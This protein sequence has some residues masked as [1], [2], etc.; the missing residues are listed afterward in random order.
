[1]AGRQAP[2]MHVIL[3]YVV[4]IMIYYSAI[5]K[6]MLLQITNPISQHDVICTAMI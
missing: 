5:S 4:S 1:M 6:L 3:S 2:H